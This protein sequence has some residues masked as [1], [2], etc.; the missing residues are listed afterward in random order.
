MSLYEIEDVGD[1]ENFRPLTYDVLMDH[2]LSVSVD[3][4]IPFAFNNVAELP[5]VEFIYISPKPPFIFKL[6]LSSNTTILALEVPVLSNHFK[7]LL[8]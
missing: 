5:L 1:I 8:F 7:Y 3:N 2:N 6:S 4:H